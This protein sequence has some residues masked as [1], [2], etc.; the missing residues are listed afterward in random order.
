MRRKL[1]AYPEVRQVLSQTGRPNDGTDATRFLQ[2]RAPCGYISRER[3]GKRTLESG[4]DREDARGSGDLSGVDFNF[5]QP[6]SDNV[7]EAASGVKGS[8]AVE[9]LRQGFI[10]ESEKRAVEVFKVLEHRRRYRGS[11]RYPEYRPKPELRIEL[12]GVS[13]SPPR[14]GQ[15][16]RAIHYRDGDRR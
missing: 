14:R 1:A 12:N 10:A 3:V 9:S 7:E 16:G 15:G 2:Y 8:I 5:S 13:F 4:P 11:G 6:I